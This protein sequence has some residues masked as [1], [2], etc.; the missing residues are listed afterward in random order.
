MGRDRVE[1]T[2]G[3]TEPAPDR[4]SSDGPRHRAAARRPPRWRG[5]HLGV[6]RD[7]LDPHR[8]DGPLGARATR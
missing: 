1:S 3:S 5:G 7:E 8:R 6:G 2:G 4:G